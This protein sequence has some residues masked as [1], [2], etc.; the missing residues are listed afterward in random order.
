M[1][2]KLFLMAALLAPSVAYAANPSATLSTQV[3]PAG[4]GSGACQ[5]ADQS[6]GIIPT[7]WACDKA[8]SADFDHVTSL[9]AIFHSGYWGA[10]PSPCA[11]NPSYPY[12]FDVNGLHMYQHATGGSNWDVSPYFAGAAVTGGAPA[13]TPFYVEY[14]RSYLTDGGGGTI[15]DSDFWLGGNSPDP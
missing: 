1:I 3:V 7:G 15:D 2:K 14:S 5:D 10:S 6:A 4:P 13:Q 12:T 8:K 11:F 9:P